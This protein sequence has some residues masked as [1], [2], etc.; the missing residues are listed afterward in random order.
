MSHAAQEGRDFLAS[1]DAWFRPVNLE[2]GPDGALYVVDMHRA[3]IEHPQYMPS[4]LQQRP[5]L[6]LG[7]DRGR[8]Y[9]IVKAGDKRPAVRPNLRGDSTAQLVELL[10]HPNAWW[11]ETAARLLLERDDPAASPALQALATSAATAPRVQALWLLENLKHLDPSTIARALA[12]NDP[13]VR[14]QG[15]A[16]AEPRLAADDGLRS[17]IIAAAGDDDPR[18]RFQVALVLGGLKGEDVSAALARIALAAHADIWTRAAVSTELPEHLGQTVTAV[19]QSAALATQPQDAS[20]LGL[21]KDLATTLGASREPGQIGPVLKQISNQADL[22]SEAA[23]TGLAVGLERRG[24]TLAEIV[25][26]LPDADALA[27]ALR[28]RLEQIGHSVQDDSLSEP[29]RAAKIRLLKYAPS[30]RTA[31]LLLEIVDASPSRVL[32][33][34]AANALAGQPDE[35]VGPRLIDTY[36]A[37][38]PAVRSAILDTLIVRPANAARLLDELES[39]RIAALSSA[40]IGKNGLPTMAISRC[41]SCAASILTTVPPADRKR[42]LDDYQSALHLASDPAAGKL[43]FRKHCATCHHIGDVGVDVAPDISDS[44]VKTPQQLLVDILNP[45]Q[46]IDNNYTS[47]SV[48]THDGQI[49]TGIIAAETATSISLRQPE[50]KT[51]DVLRADVE[52]VRSNGVSLMPEGFEKELSKQ[53]LADL[54]AFV[55]NWRYLDQPIPGTL[56][57]T[58]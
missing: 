46:A 28:K 37:Q 47:Y 23:L 6:R 3:V 42:V 36:A 35:H 57:G 48:V 34:A 41:A 38:T 54:I 39:R 58:Q 52:A 12:D 16:L 56:Q 50:N 9:R 22:A 8:L 30:P 18:V 32:R 19:L 10:E 25:A 2:I 51:V 5:D 7:D 33:N 1:D 11:R 27:A 26:Q 31:E 44:R 21:V 4:E 13:Q 43:L 45:N 24:A 53:Q 40:L 29:L 14:A 20:M 17:A 49:H 55:K 15:V